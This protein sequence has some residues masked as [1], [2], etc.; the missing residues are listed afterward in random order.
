VITNSDEDIEFNEIN[1]Y[2]YIYL[3]VKDTKKIESTIR[4]TD[5]GS[6]VYLAEQSKINHTFSLARIYG[7]SIMYPKILRHTPIVSL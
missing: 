1:C 2:D 6:I 3:Q 7:I 4:S 5:L